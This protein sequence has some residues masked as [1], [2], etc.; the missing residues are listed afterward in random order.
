MSTKNLNKL[1]V[2]QALKGLKNKDFTVTDL[3]NDCYEQIENHDKEIKVFITLTKDYAL[4]KAKE[5]DTEL[6]TRGE[7]VFEEK[8]RSL[9]GWRKLQWRIGIG[10]YDRTG[11]R[12]LGIVK[13]KEN[14]RQSGKCIFGGIEERWHIVVYRLQQHR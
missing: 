5:L 9:C 14:I 2:V 8:R 6:S 3:V 10:K 7:L 13:R 1:T 4:N 12:Q 11:N